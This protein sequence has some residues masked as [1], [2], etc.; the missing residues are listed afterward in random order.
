MCSV[1]VFPEGDETVLDREIEAL[2]IDVRQLVR[3][4]SDL[5]I[6]PASRT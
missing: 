2:L 4:G 5:S 6:E 1:A 3:L